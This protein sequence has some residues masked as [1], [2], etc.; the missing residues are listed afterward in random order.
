MIPNKN[1]LKSIFESK[2]LAYAFMYTNS[3]LFPITICPKDGSSVKQISHFQYKCKKKSCRK[4]YSSYG[5]SPLKKCR[6]DMNDFLYLLYLWTCKVSF[7]SALLITGHSSKTV[8][9]IYRFCV[10]SVS[11]DLNLVSNQIGGPGIIVQLDE[12]KFGKRKYNRGHSVEGVWVF[13]GVDITPARNVFAVV[14]ESRDM[15]TLNALCL[16]YVKPGS[17]VVTDGWRGYAEFKRNEDFSHKSVNH[18]IEFVNAEGYHTNNI[19][20][21]WSGMKSVI[22]PRM[23][24]RSLMQGKL[25]E[26]IWRRK[27]GDDLWQ[28]LLNSIKIY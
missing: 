10:E 22:K 23:R 12:S 8:S 7:T 2:E 17:I 4:I 14:V 1:Q 21:T 5:D 9:K 26:F 11:I 27:H 13:G 15:Q 20:G 6:I 18:S 25:F 3:M 16:Q 24:I 28:S 19:E